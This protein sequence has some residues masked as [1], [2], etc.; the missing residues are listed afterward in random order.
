MECPEGETLADRLR[1]SP[2][3]LNQVLKVGWRLVRDLRRQ[4]LHRYRLGPLI[5]SGEHLEVGPMHNLFDLGA[6][7]VSRFFAPSRAGQKFYAVTYSPG[8]DA[9]F[10]VTFNWKALLRE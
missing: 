1:K 3:P 2:L 5:A 6:H 9:P 4:F 10:T 8:S 7:P